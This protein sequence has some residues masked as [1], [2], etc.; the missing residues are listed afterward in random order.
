MPT[1]KFCIRQWAEGLPGHQI[2]P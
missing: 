2:C 1:K